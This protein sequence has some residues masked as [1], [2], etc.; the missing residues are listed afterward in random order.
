MKKFLKLV[1]L[2]I[3]AITV[4]SYSQDIPDGVKRIVEQLKTDPAREWGFYDAK[5]SGY[6]DQKVKFKNFIPGL[7]VECYYLD[8]DKLDT[9]DL[10][11]PINKLIKKSN[12]WYIPI[13]VDNSYSYHVLVRLKGGDFI[14]V[15]CG[16][17]PGIGFRTE[18]E[19]DWDKVRE[20][21][22][23]ST[24]ISPLCIIDG[25]RQ[26]LHFPNEK[27]NNLF[28]FRHPK[29]DDSISLMTSRS[30]DSLDDAEKVLRYRKKEWKAFIKEREK[31][32]KENPGNKKRN[33]GIDE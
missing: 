24:G 25:N 32:S 9:A 20:K 31:L 2:G 22:P 28:Y 30:L 18:K 23:E 17:G 4:F 19:N 10:S 8:F 33:G 7:P 13:L 14:L 6:I 12:L 5:G 11:T 29:F 26:F 15:G 3:I 27:P 1:L 16:G 21:Y